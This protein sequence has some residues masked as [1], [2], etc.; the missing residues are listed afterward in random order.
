MN[1]PPRDRKEPLF[2]RRTIILSLLQGTAVLAVT[3]GL[4]G[5]TYNQ[6]R[7][8]DVARSL[9]FITLVIANL[10]LILSNRVWSENIISSLR[11]KNT[12]LA[13]IVVATIA[14][15]TLVLSVPVL[16]DLFK[17]GPLYFNDLAMAIE[18]GVVC[19]LWF[20]LVKLLNRPN[21]KT[22]NIA[23]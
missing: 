19:I 9:T 16:R 17:F 14:L 12:P 7:G 10:G 8:E 20:E 11:H 1:R 22:I 18:A 13:I 2:S 15:L 23:E 6:G 5:I 3:A 4:Y 21:V